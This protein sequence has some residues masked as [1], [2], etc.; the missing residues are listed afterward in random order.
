MA[1]GAPDSQPLA[2]GLSAQQLVT[3]MTPAVTPDA[4]NALVNA[5]HNGFVNTQDII[6]RIGAVGQAK[7]KA[8]LE[9]LGEYVSPE[10]IQA[11]KSQIQA[12]GAQANLQTAQAQGGQQLVQPLTESNLADIVQHNQTRLSGDAVKAYTSLHPPIYKIDANGNPTSE[13]DYTAMTREGSELLQAMALR[14]YSQ[15]R[16]QGTWA[17]YYDDKLKQTRKAFINASG[18][19]VTPGSDRWKYYNQLRDQAFERIWKKPD[20]SPHFDPSLGE[21]DS[22]APDNIVQPI[23]PT[24]TPTLTP[25]QRGQAVQQYAKYLQ[26]S[27]TIADPDKAM[28]FAARANDETLSGYA[29]QSGLITPIA[30]PDVHAVIPSPIPGSTSPDFTSFPAAA[31]SSYQP[32]PAARKELEELPDVKA[33]YT[34]KPVYVGFVDAAKLAKA[35]PTAVNDLGLAESF[36]K[37]FDPQSTLREFKFDALKESIPWPQKLKDAWPLIMKTHTFPADVRADIINSGRNVIDSREKALQSRFQAAEAR[38]PG[39]LAADPEQQQI[40]KGIPF[41]AR[42]GLDDS[43]NAATTAGPAVTLPSG[44]TVRW[45]PEAPVQ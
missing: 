37:L 6:D 44:R 16:L 36:S 43:N 27:G 26:A 22:K 35:R 14:D 38:N 40:M 2:A 41:S 25:E 11:R 20:N 17:D 15:Q 21:G 8:L 31:S 4:V 29:Q 34:S 33:F 7:K 19:N 13:Y 23:T 45:V 28:G 3:P 12:A 42:Y 9:S 5:Y 24:T 10:A 39:L 18:E 30:P 32:D 1:A